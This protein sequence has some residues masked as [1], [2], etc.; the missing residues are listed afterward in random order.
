MSDNLPPGAASYLAW[1]EAAADE[2]EQAQERAW[3]RLEEEAPDGVD[4]ELTLED[5]GRNGEYLFNFRD[6]GGY[7]LDVTVDL[8]PDD[9]PP[10]WWHD[11]E[12]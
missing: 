4:W 6:G 5:R 2:Y 11:W 7:E 1:Q 10:D 3:E 12:D 8:S 9:E